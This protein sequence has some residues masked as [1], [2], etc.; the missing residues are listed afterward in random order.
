MSVILEGK[1]KTGFSVDPGWENLREILQIPAH[2]VFVE[3]LILGAQTPVLLFRAAVSRR[4]N[5]RERYSQDF[6]IVVHSITFS[7]G[8]LIY[9][10]KCR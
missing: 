1:I 7:Q 6:V 9:E 3:V 4:L 5:N 2:P 10:E 8:Q